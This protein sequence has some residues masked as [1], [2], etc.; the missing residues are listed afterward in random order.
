MLAEGI[1]WSLDRADCQ[2]IRWAQ[3]QHECSYPTCC[4]PEHQPNSNPP[5][6]LSEIRLGEAQDCKSSLLL[7]TF[8]FFRLKATEL[9]DS[10]RFTSCFSSSKS[11]KALLFR[12]CRGTAICVSEACTQWNIVI[13]KGKET[14]NC[15]WT[16]FS[17]MYDKAEKNQMQ[18]D[19]RLRS[20]ERGGVRVL[21]AARKNC[22]DS[23][24]K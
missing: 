21:A 9:L 20:R 23:P 8:A 4:E 19:K 24:L 17:W 5:A 11:A 22:L 18:I 16:L 10:L 15:S 2:R 12:S 6:Q 3:R 7:H 1:T 14:R 13:K